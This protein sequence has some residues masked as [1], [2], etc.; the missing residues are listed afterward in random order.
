MR[1]GKSQHHPE[2]QLNTA[3]PHLQD[4]FEREKTQHHSVEN[5]HDG[6]IFRTKAE[7]QQNV[8]RKEGVD[9]QDGE[10]D[11]KNVLGAKMAGTGWLTVSV[12]TCSNYTEYK[13]STTSL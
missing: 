2:L 5:G 12:P 6:C 13:H 8:G 3:Y 10:G 7:D 4:A 11:G 1:L 9:G